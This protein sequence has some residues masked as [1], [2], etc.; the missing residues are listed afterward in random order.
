MDGGLG[1]LVV[2]EVSAESLGNLDDEAQNLAT[3]QVLY[4]DER[5]V[6]DAQGPKNFNVTDLSP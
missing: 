6:D 3:E 5:I 1:E 2:A 4:A